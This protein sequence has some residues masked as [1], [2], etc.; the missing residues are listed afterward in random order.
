MRL[1]TLTSRASSWVQTGLK[2]CASVIYTQVVPVS[3][4]R[5]YISITVLKNMT[6]AENLCLDCSSGPTTFVMGERKTVVEETQKH[7]DLHFFS[8]VLQEMSLGKMHLF[9]LWQALTLVMQAWLKKSCGLWSE[10]VVLVMVRF[11]CGLKTGEVAHISNTLQN[12]NT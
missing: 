6:S 9:R 2:L 4:H 1:L 3:A 11:P 7:L 12:L 5:K 10:G 8:S